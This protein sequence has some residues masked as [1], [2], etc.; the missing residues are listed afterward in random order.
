MRSVNSESECSVG[1]GDA[2]MGGSGG[3]EMCGAGGCVEGEV[4]A[5]DNGDGDVYGSGE[6]TG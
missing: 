6:E 4:G 1:R 5:E 3:A 2:E